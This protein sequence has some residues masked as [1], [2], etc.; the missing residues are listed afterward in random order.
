MLTSNKVV[1]K[2]NF[3]V[4]NDRFIHFKINA[5]LCREIFAS[6]IE[7]AVSGMTKTEMTCQAP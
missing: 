5:G 6:I 4:I 3:V 2:S 1:R 7:V